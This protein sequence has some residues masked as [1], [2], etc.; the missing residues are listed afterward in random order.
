M[1][2][3]PIAK[4]GSQG[5]AYYGG[6]QTLCFIFKSVIVIVIDTMS[7]PIR[8]WRIQEGQ[9]AYTGI[10][11]GQLILRKI[12]KIGATRCQILR[13]KCTIIRFPLPRPLIV[14]VFKR[15]TSKGRKR[16]GEGKARRKG[17]EG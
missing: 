7:D 4:T 9:S 1:A 16:K 17:S 14:A 13:L 3:R 5:Q 8:Q 10:H 12:S 15:P 6:P 11:C 2:S